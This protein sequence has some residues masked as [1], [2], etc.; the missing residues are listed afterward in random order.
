[1]RFED[2]S[3]VVRRRSVLLPL[4]TAGLLG[5]GFGLSALYQDG[6]MRSPDIGA[7]TI[8][9]PFAKFTVT[10]PPSPV[11]DI[12]VATLDGTEI[13]L[14]Q[15]LNRPAILNIWATWCAPCVRELPALA[16]LQAGAGGQFL[17]LTL[18]IDRG[19]RRDVEP[20]LAKAGIVGLPVLLD[21]SG[22]A[23]KALRLRGLPTTLLIDGQ[24]RERG[25][26]E[27]D[28]PWD[29]AAALDLIARTLG[30]GPTGAVR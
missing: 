9:D 18:S 13:A 28:A 16:R 8:R 12:A 2:I 26:L 17:V 30:T 3:A 25:R 5:L 15:R 23:L 1:M 19:G 24:G 20:F 7:P 10:E 21:P 11:P 4:A 29:S 27:G 22:A 6:A 14:A